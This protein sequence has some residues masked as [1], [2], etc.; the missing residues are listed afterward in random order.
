M[1]YWTRSF[2]ISYHHNSAMVVYM[3]IC[4]RGVVVEWICHRTVDHEVHG[5]SL[6]AAL[7]SFGKILIYL[8]TFDP[9]EVNGYLVGLFLEMHCP[10]IMAVRA[11]ARIINSKTLWKRIA[12]LYNVICAIQE[13]NIIIIIIILFAYWFHAA[14]YKQCDFEADLCSVWSQLADDAFDWTRIQGSKMSQL[15]FDHTLDSE[16]GK[17]RRKCLTSFKMFCLWW[18]NYI[19]TMCTFVK[20]MNRRQLIYF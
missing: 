6:A 20:I 2:V 19:S 10:L 3:Y 18:S 5:S 9:G 15:R 16:D 13:P 1:S 7:M 8:A 11:K 4:D 12:T 17:P 14:T